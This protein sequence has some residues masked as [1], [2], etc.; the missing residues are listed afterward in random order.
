M[1]RKSEER[2]EPEIE[3]QV[4]KPVGQDY[5]IRALIHTGD[6][7]RRRKEDAQFRRSKKN[8]K[9]GRQ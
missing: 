6:K 1:A 8:R 3:R 5:A 2:M 9:T 7:E 4:R